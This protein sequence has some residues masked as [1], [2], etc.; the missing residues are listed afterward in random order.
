[1]SSNFS[2]LD[3]RRTDFRRGLQT[4]LARYN[5]SREALAEKIVQDILKIFVS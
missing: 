5:N 2:F 4:A 3:N 1:M